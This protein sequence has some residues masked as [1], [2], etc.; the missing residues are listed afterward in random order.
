MILAAGVTEVLPGAVVLIGQDL[1][2]T[3]RFT[4]DRRK[5]RLMMS[6]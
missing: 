6:Y 3:C 1:L 4:D 2:V 5:R